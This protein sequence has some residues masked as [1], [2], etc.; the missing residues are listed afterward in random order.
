MLKIL[1]ILLRK[2][3]QV[4]VAIVESVKNNDEQCQLI[5]YGNS[6]KENLERTIT[7]DCVIFLVEKC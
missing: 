1:C 6:I 5:L 7:D 4:S 3:S 2:Y